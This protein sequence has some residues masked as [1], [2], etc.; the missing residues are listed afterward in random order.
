M[1]DVLRAMY[2][3]KAAASPGI[4]AVLDTGDGD[5]PKNRYLDLVHRRALRRYLAVLGPRAADLGCGVGRL[6]GLLAADHGGI[7]VDGSPELLAIAR[8]RLPRGTPLVQADLRRL[9]LASG[10]MTGALMAFVSLHFDEDAAAR[11][12]ADV[13]RVLQPGGHLILL[14]H[15]SPAEDRV[16]HGV[17]DRSRSSL[18]RVLRAAGLET[19][20]FRALKKSPSRV[21][22]WIRAG[23]LPESLWT[24]G[25][26]LDERL[27][28]KRPEA[29]DYLECL[30]IARKPGNEGVRIER[31]GLASLFIPRRFLERRG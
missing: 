6:T 24:L 2:R 9:P 3:T 23:R 13:A 15:V 25:A 12:F 19:V 7:G 29:A 17:L 4:G 18:E 1:N 27:C 11:A 16:Y 30:L 26:W 14:E 22:H 20:F 5:G 31:A 28:A 10:S 8:T 21:V